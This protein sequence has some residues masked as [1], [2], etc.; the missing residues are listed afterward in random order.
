MSSSSLRSLR[1]LL[2]NPLSRQRQRGTVVQADVE[3]GSFLRPVGLN[4]VDLF[5]IHTDIAAG[6][7]KQKAGIGGMSRGGIGR[8]DGLHKELRLDAI[9]QADGQPSGS[10]AHEGFD[11]SIPL[12]HS[13][14]SLQM[15]AA[16]VFL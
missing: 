2:L 10:P 4:L 7:G 14:D 3:G 5:L 6:A 11:G 15:L 16:A 9:A 13:P 8:R 1:G 12:A